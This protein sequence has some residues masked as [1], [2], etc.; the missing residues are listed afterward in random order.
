[1]TNDQEK[2]IKILTE[3]LMNIINEVNNQ[4][5]QENVNINAQTYFLLIDVA[6]EIAAQ[7]KISKKEQMECIS[8]FMKQ[9]KKNSIKTELNSKLKNNS[10]ELSDDLL[11]S[12][13]ENIESSF[14]E[15][16]VTEINMLFEDDFVAKK[17][18]N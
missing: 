13:E 18:K 6:C 7:L 1:M 14:D 2:F 4:A 17:D 10:I 5:L 3:K 9:N 11:D 8:Y 16:I 12:A 15:D